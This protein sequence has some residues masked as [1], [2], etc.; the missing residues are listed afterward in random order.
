[1]KI[2][3][4]YFN[5]TLDIHKIIIRLNNRSSGGSNSRQIQASSTEVEVRSDTYIDLLKIRGERCHRHDFSRKVLV[6]QTKDLMGVANR[7]IMASYSG[8]LK[9]LLYLLTIRRSESIR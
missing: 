3:H 4:I 5:A 9:N 2:V 6:I 8:K 7:T 1:M